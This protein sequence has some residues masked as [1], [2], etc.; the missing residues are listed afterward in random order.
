MVRSDDETYTQWSTDYSKENN[1]LSVFNMIFDIYLHHY[2]NTFN[3]V[4]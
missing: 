3:K 2:K 1:F 4:M